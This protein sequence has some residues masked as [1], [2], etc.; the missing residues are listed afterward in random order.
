[1]I[2]YSLCAGL[3]LNLLNLFSFT[4]FFKSCLGILYIY[5]FGEGKT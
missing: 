2:L 5:V 4:H 3:E 1:M